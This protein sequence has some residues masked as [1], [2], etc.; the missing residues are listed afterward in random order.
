LLTSL[1][2]EGRKLRCVYLDY[3][4]PA[5]FREK[6]SAKLVALRLSIPLEI[7]DVHGLAEMQ[8]GYVPSAVGSGDELDVK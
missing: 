7:I 2:Q 5:S 1:K 8:N 4:K 6:A 3:G